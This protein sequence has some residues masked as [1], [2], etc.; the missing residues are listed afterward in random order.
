MQPCSSVPTH[1]NRDGY[2]IRYDDDDNLLSDGHEIDSGDDVPGAPH[3]APVPY[4]PRVELVY[5]VYNDDSGD[6]L[7]FNSSDDEEVHPESDVEGAGDDAG[8]GDEYDDH[9]GR[10]VTFTREIVTMVAEGDVKRCGSEG[11]ARLTW[12]CFG[13]LLHPDVSR[14]VSYEGMMVH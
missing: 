11:V 8:G 12:K 7:K 6:D 2:W 4:A 1:L 3:I 14:P 13:D 5:N 10:V 9:K